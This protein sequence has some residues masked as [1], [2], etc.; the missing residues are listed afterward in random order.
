MLVDLIET[1]TSDGVRLHGALQRPG[2][3][4]ADHNTAG[5]RVADAA[6]LLSGVGSNFYGSGLMAGLSEACAAAGLLALRVNTRGH[7][8]VCT[9]KTRQGGRLQGAAFEIVDDCRHDIAS[10][11]DALLQ[12]GARRVALVGHSLGAIKALYSQ[13]VQPHTAVSAVI[14]VSPPRLNHEMF[15][16]GDASRAFAES[17]AQAAALLADGQ[18]DQLFLA[19]VP[20]PMQ[21]SAA[22]YLDKYGPASRYDILKFAHR[23]ASTRAFVYGEQELH[24]GSVAFAGLD[25]AV[26]ELAWESPPQVLTLPGANHFYHGC[27]AELARVVLEVLST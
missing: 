6:L 11:V 19:R 24:S 8:T 18:P 4:E 10:W 22:T 15:Q 13:A 12:R 5:D 27:E 3:L 23:A 1:W 7:D 17:H 20:F 25:Q 21:M 9:V 14:A 26:A 16:Q 2:G